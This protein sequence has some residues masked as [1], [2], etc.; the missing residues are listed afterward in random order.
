[1]QYVRHWTLDLPFVLDFRKVRINKNIVKSLKFRLLLCIIKI[2]GD[3][4]ELNNLGF[5]QFLRYKN[6]RPHF[7]NFKTR[8]I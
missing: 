8:R 1:M 5:S 6:G 2:V 3:T 4:K 7:E